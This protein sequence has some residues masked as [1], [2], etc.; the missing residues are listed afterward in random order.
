MDYNALVGYQ[1]GNY[2]NPNPGT[3]AANQ[4][5]NY[6]LPAWLAGEFGYGNAFQGTQADQTYQAP[7]ADPYASL[8]AH[9][10]PTAASV[11]APSSASYGASGMASGGGGETNA[12]NAAAGS[13]VGGEYNLGGDLMGMAGAIGNGLAG[14]L[15]FGSGP[16]QNVLDAVGNAINGDP[17][18][19][20]GSAQQGYDASQASADT[21][22]ASGPDPNA[23]YKGGV[24]TPN[25]L[26]GTPNN[27]HDNG[28]GELQVGEGVL[29]RSALAHYGKDIVA[30]LNKL[31]IPKSAL[32]KG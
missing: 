1:S 27:P 23:Q 10:N 22:G 4:S 11:T 25:K 7:G 17:N 20:N 9:P 26:T 19:L 3:G 30:K 8:P 32:S 21:S 5:L 29:T 6:Q 24:V 16:Q 14:A 28:W 15:G 2:S 18:Q 13:N 31:A 12:S